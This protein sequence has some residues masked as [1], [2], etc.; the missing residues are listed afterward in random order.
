MGTSYSI[1]YVADVERPM[2]EVAQTIEQTLVSVNKSMSTYD[3]QSELSRFNQSTSTDWQAASP[4][5]FSVLQEAK[6]IEL[7]GQ[8][9]FDVTV[10]PA[11]NL[12][13]F[14]PDGERKIPAAVA[15][16]AARKRIGGR[17]LFVDPVSKRIRK[18]MPELYVDLSAIA[19]G[20][21]VDRVGETLESLGLK[22]YMVEIGGEVRTRGLRPDQTSWRIGIEAPKEGAGSY[23]RILEISGKSI[24]TSGNYRNFFNSGGKLYS[25]TIDPIT[26]KPVVHQLIS[27]SVVDD[28]CMTADALAT[29][30]MVMGPVRGKEFVEQH[31]MLAFFIYQEGEK[32]LSYASTAFQAFFGGAP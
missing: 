14:G 8:G 20:Y 11:V 21:G 26:A 32:T 1:K 9:T 10:G 18:D 28:S 17:H 12:W 16:E 15:I 27:V 25:H 29:A 3:K 7:M 22:N 23:A 30:L 13:G 2:Q 6:R 31:R 24:A 19:K 4:E 5:L